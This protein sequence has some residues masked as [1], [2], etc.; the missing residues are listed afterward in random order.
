MTKFYGIFQQNQNNWHREAG[1]STLAIQTLK[2]ATAFELPAQYF[3]F[4]SW[5]NGGEGELPVDPYWF[6]IWPAEE[7]MPAN[8]ELQVRHMRRDTLASETMVQMKCWRL[9]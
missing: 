5:T 9:T 1:A 6:I 2:N 3:E 8:N 4:L 7:V